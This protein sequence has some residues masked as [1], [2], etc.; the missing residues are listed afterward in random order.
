MTDASPTDALRARSLEAALTVADVR[1]SLAW[2]RDVLGF[3]V[4]REFER[5]GALFAASVRAG[6]VRLLLS[7]DTGARGTE[8]TKG[9]GFSLQMTTAQDI[10]ALAAAVVARG[11]ELDTPPSEAWGA[12]FFRLR[13]PDGFRFTISSPH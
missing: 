5:D 9:E 11:A 8:R 6:D 2:Y 4:D 1:A 3:T 10:D 12:R 7:Q 13:D